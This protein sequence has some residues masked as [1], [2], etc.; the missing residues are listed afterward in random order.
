LPTEW[1]AFPQAATVK[2]TG[3]NTLLKLSDA[4]LTV[5]YVRIVLH[6][7]S[8]T[9]PKNSRDI[10][11]R[12][13]YAI[14]EI[15]LGT[16]NGRSRFN[17]AIDHGVGRYKQ[18]DIYVSS[19]DPWHRAIDRDDQTE[20]P[21]FDFVFGTGLTNRLPLLV[22]VA[23]LY[24]TPEN[25]VAEVRYLQARGYPVERIEMGE[26][27]DGQFVTPEHYGTLYLQFEKAIHKINPA[28]QLG[29]PSLQDIEQS[30]VPGRIEFGKA[31]WMSRFLE[32]LKHRGQLDKFTFFSFEW[33]PFGDD[34][35]PEQ[36]AEGT[37][38]LTDA[39]NELQQ[40]SLT[41]DIPWLITEYGYSAFGARAEVDLDG[42]LLNAD[43]VARFLTMG[44]ET[45][46]LYGYEA[47]E[48]IKEQECSSG[49][50]MLFFRDDR[51]HI[52]KP[53]ATYWGARLL[54]QEWVQPGDQSHE[55]YPA[56]S[57]VRNGNGDQMI[58]AYA[59]H[60][61]D[62]L[63][64]LLLINKD[65]QRAYETSVVFRNAA[66]A[67]GTFDGR[68]DIFQYSSKQYQLGGPTNNP[69]PVRADEPEHRVIQSSRET[70]TQIS[71]PPYSLTVVRGG[72]DAVWRE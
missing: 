23:V 38:M 35:H 14:R 52:K 51:G 68:L 17:D 16:L 27:P 63:W 66:G 49:N 2:G 39:L 40:G 41:H 70:P 8:E 42:A 19:T 44:G 32:Y 29:G 31:G 45:A 48:I 1:H 57:D 47:S 12:L 62:G 33:Y 30:Q 13:G 43:S 64:S 50:N 71:L 55:I 56:V 25:A 69:Y 24:D 54:T 34:C 36:L 28:L 11:D 61:P 53:T 60:R 18:T 5:R 72:L 9:A 65:P 59:V 22:P 10:R 7:S 67:T 37:Q 6:E 20:Q 4:P 3:G 46:Y 26:E 58:T 21:G 15:Y